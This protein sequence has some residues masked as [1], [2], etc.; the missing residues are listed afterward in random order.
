MKISAV[1]KQRPALLSIVIFT[2]SFEKDFLGKGQA[3]LCLGRGRGY[4]NRSRQHLPQAHSCGQSS[5]RGSTPP[6]AVPPRCSARCQGGPSQ[7]LP[8]SGPRPGPTRP[9]RTPAACRRCLLP[10]GPRGRPTPSPRLPGGKAPRGWHSSRGCPP[11]AWG[12]SLLGRKRGLGVTLLPLPVDDWTAFY[13]P[14]F[15]YFPQLCNLH[16]S[17]CPEDPMLFSRRVAFRSL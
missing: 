12:P 5:R 10:A 11:A 1:S 13:H 2:L 3:A 17:C 14:G 4:L 6:G 16:P 15:A 8:Q 7:N 9:S